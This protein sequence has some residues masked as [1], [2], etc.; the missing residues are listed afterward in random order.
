MILKEPLNNNK[1]INVI[2]EIKKASPSA[3]IIIKRL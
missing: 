1:E 3:G 2:S